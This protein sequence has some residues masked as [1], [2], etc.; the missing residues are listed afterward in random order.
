MVFC[1]GCG[2]EIHET[3]PTC[4]K[5]GAL[6]FVKPYNKLIGDS[7]AGSNKKQ[8]PLLLTGLIACQYFYINKPAKNVLFWASFFLF[9]GFFWYFYDLYR[10]I[11]GVFP[12]ENDVNI[13]QWN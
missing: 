13:D 1:R 12:D 9:I 7:G 10:I 6:Q 4:P 8:L 3:A 11:T 2:K 5:C